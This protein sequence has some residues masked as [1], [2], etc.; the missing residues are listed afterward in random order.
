MNKVALQEWLKLPQSTKR[1]IFF[2]ISE[3]MN[4][5]DAAV[6]YY[7]PKAIVQFLTEL[8]LL[9]SIS[10]YTTFPID[11]QLKGLLV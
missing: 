3:K 2:E 8:L 9:H 7:P 4:L 5:P 11:K 1:N 6:V 10:I